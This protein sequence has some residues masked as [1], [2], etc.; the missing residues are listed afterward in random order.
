MAEIFCRQAEI[1]AAP[2]LTER[3]QRPLLA[4]LR[5]MAPADFDALDTGREGAGRRL[6]HAVQAASS[7]SEVLDAAVTKRYPRSR[8]R[9]M[10]LWAYLGLVPGRTPERV[11]YLRVLSAN[12][13]GR[14]V[15]SRMRRTA[16]VPV[17]MRPAALRRAGAQAQA[18]FALECRGADLY[19]LA[20]PEIGPCGKLQRQR[21]VMV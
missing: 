18:L 15:L 2:A 19:A 21:A 8:L 9:R 16:A 14:A 4:C 5:R 3:L 6:F 1:G 11:P 7:L 20:C 10:M 12:E 13:R 17:V